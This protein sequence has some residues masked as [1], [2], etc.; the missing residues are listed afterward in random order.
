[1]VKA[2]LCFVPIGGGENDYSVELEMPHAP[3]VGDIIQMIDLE[4]DHR[5]FSHDF[6]VSEVRWEFHKS[7]KDVTF[8]SIK[9]EC[10]Y[11]ISSRS[12]D[13]HRRAYESSLLESPS[14]KTRRPNELRETMF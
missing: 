7:G 2:Y 13:Q 11:A 6:K 12:C 14:P 8:A 3:A 4:I 5:R 9:V 10:E 1:M